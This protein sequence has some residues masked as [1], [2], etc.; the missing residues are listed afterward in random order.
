M[1]DHTLPALTDLLEQSQELEPQAC[2]AAAR[3]LADEG[4]EPDEKKAFLVALQ[5]KGESP[6]EV[7][8]IAAA[9]REMARDPG[10]V[11]RQ[12][13]EDAIDFVGTGGDGS[14]A[15]NISTTV[16]FFLAAAGVTVLKHGNRGATSPSGS[17]DL[18]EAVGFPIPAG[19]PVMEQL[20][21]QTHFAF[22]FAPAFHPAF[23]SIVPVRK[24][25]AAE[26]QRTVFNILGPLINPARPALQVLGVF[27]PDW[28]EPMAGV[29]ER[30]ELRRGLV[31]HGQPDDGG[32]LDKAS[33]AG[34]T[35][36]RGVGELSDVRLTLEPEAA[37]FARCSMDDLKGGDAAANLKRLQAL[38]AGKANRGLTDSVLLNAGLGF[39]AA[40][41]ADSLEAGVTLARTVL[42][43]GAVSGWLAETRRFLKTLEPEA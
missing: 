14:G 9:F 26:K 29:L 11:L 17:A 12:K 34:P 37:G 21:R 40:G 15:F 24:E 13:A 3:L 43:E 38:L 42:K 2:H 30:L 35:L 10:P 28:V 22:F 6:A 25:L 7:A 19:P 36:V 31:L 18:L 39:W 20:I 4:V 32:G 16:S 5:R 41:K 27:N 1:A 33:C 23:K 8:A